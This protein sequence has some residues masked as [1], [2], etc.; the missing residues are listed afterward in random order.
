MT[1]T[2]LVLKPLTPAEAAKSRSIS[3]PARSGQARERENAQTSPLQ[4]TNSSE[5]SFAAEV[6]QQQGVN[7]STPSPFNQQSKLG[8]TQDFDRGYDQGYDRAY[9]R[10][11]ATP[12]SGM[13]S[14]GML[15][16]LQE[17]SPK[18]KR[19]DGTT[20]DTTLD[21]FSVDTITQA[22]SS[23]NP[24]AP[25][26]LAAYGQASTSVDRTRTAYAAVIAS[27]EANKSTALQPATPQQST[28]SPIVASSSDNNTDTT[29]SNTAGFQALSLMP[30]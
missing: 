16:T 8:N 19:M 29:D 1:T 17:N 23:I 4:Q 25:Q 13:L 3:G 6:M 15:F 10:G 11:I 26:A 28:P 21:R 18:N 27:K 2:G 5:T 20:A 24:A 12:G 9:D 30:A 7:S 14:S 22:T